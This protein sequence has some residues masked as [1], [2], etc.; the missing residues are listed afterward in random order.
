MKRL[1]ASSARPEE[2]FRERKSEFPGATTARKIG[3]AAGGQDQYERE[4]DHEGLMAEKY[5]LP[6]DIRFWQKVRFGEGMDDCWEWTGFCY[7]TGHGQFHYDDQ[8]WDIK[9]SRAIWLMYNGPLERTDYICH[10][11]GN[12][13]LDHLYKGTHETNQAD[14]RGKRRH[15]KAHFVKLDWA[16]VNEIRALNVPAPVHRKTIR[17]RLPPRLYSATTILRIWRGDDKG[18]WRKGI[19]AD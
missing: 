16:K 19:G 5:K 12:P 17:G 13:R 18:G 4:P 10:K 3:R 8:L 14:E 6:V 7:P 2:L 11:C 1:T 15:D 9:A